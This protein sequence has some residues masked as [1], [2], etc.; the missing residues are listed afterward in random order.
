MGELVDPQAMEPKGGTLE[1]RSTMNACLQL[2]CLYQKTLPSKGRKNETVSKLDFCHAEFISASRF[3]DSESTFVAS[4]C[5]CGVAVRNDSSIKFGM[6]VLYVNDIIA[7]YLTFFL[8]FCKVQIP[9]DTSR[10]RMVKKQWQQSALMTTRT[11]KRQLSALREW[12]KK[13][14]L[15]VNGRSVNTTKSLLQSSTARTRLCSA[16]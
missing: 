6:T 11:L 12:L 7:G 14:V 10:A 3:K 8:E 9:E 2:L 1:S 5:E 4:A 15:S 13:K 16:S